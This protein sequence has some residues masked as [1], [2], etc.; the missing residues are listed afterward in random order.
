MNK[1]CDWK[2]LL[3]RFVQTRFLGSF[4]GSLIACEQKSTGSFG[5][6]IRKEQNI[7]SITSCF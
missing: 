7:L 6:H 3:T 2:L 4:K 1:P 5:V